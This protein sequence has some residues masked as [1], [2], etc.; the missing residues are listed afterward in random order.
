MVSLETDCIIADTTGTFKLIAGSSSFIKATS[1]V[2]KLTFSGIHSLVV[3]LGNNKNSLKVLDISGNILHIYP[4]F[5]IFT[6]IIT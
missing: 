3:K 4:P 2:F 1:G 6:S 5:K